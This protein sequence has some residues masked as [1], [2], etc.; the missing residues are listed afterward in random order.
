MMEINEITRKIIG[1]AID[2][3]KD[4]GPGLLGSAY[5][6]CL[7]YELSN[8]GLKF[9]KQQHVPVIYREIILEFGYRI[10]LLVEDEIIIELKVVDA[11]N[12]FHIAQVLTYMKFA[13]KPIGL[14]TNFNVSILKE[15]IRRFKR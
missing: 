13:D 7:A 11:L 12:P 4:L 1:F 14:L 10:D 8:K 3:H 9:K 15:G 6:D 5:E 2:V